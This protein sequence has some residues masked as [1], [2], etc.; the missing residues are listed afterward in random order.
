MGH[1][2]FG[3]HAASSPLLPRPKKAQDNDNTPCLG[4]PQVATQPSCPRGTR[5]RRPAHQFCVPQSRGNAFV[6]PYALFKLT[7]T[8]SVLNFSEPYRS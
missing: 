3:R 6:V 4:S 2:V 1:A 5:L 8:S 7:P